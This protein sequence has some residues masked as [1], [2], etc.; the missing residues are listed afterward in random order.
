MEKKDRR[1]SARKAV[2]RAVDYVI[3]P[4]SSEELF[5]AVMVDISEHGVGLFTTENL[6]EGQKILFRN[7]AEQSEKPAVVRWRQ[8]Y[9]DLYYRI[10]LEFLEIGD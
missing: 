9:K 4:S 1:R 2:G 7:G 6:A 3:I 10:G 5:S 8:K